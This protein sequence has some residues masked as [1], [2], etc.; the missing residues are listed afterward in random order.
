LTSQL[1][2][3]HFH[4][5]VKSRRFHRQPTSFRF[6]LTIHII[7][8][9]FDKS[10]L[11]GPGDSF[12]L[13]SPVR[14]RSTSHVLSILFDNSCPNKSDRFDQPSQFPSP[15]SDESDRVRSLSTAQISSFLFDHSALVVPNDSSSP[16]HSAPTFLRSPV[17]LRLRD[18]RPGGSRRY[19][20][21]CHGESFL[22]LR[23]L[24]SKASLV[25][26][27]YTSRYRSLRAITDKPHHALSRQVDSTTLGDAIPLFPTSHVTAFRARSVRL[28]ASVFTCRVCSLPTTPFLAG[29]RRLDY[30]DRVYSLPIDTDYARPF[31]STRLLE[32]F[33]SRPF[34][35]TRV[36]TI[37]VFSFPTLRRSLLCLRYLVL[38][39]LALLR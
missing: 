13:A 4:R 25:G 27:D 8:C 39:L 34:S 6:Y 33:H 1:T 11:S 2:S 38:L 22:V 15:R 31:S 17:Q 19:N 9:L 28:I 18:S 21:T 29:S 14:L 37:P 36:R 24:M 10:L 32:P 5:Q 16:F 3:F 23:L 26:P 12:R 7:S 20:T 30:S 35:T